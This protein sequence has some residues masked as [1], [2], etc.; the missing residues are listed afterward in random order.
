MC[1]SQC[2]YFLLVPGLVHN[3]ASISGHEHRDAVFGTRPQDLEFETTSVDRF[4]YSSFSSG[5]LDN[6]FPAPLHDV[7][8]NVLTSLELR[9]YSQC[10]NYAVSKQL[11]NWHSTARAM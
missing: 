2:T 10:W 4:R 7:L 6:Q 5:F 1:V 3:A 8:F 9:I 11:Q